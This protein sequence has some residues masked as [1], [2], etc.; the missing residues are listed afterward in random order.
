MSETTENKALMRVGTYIINRKHELFSYCD[1][2]CFKS[3][4]MRNLANYHK[5]QCYILG[6]REQIDYSK[7]QTEYIADMNKAMVL[8]NQNRLANFE[9][10]RPKRVKTA[11]DK[12]NDY[13]NNG[14]IPKS[15]SKEFKEKS[16]EDKIKF[17]QEQV[18]K[19][20]N[21]QYKAELPIGRENKLPSYDFLAF[22]FSGYLKS[23]DNP[24]KLMPAKAAQQTIR[25]LNNDWKS[26]FKSLKEY[27]KDKSKF[28][29]LP[30][31]PKYKKKDGRAKVSLSNQGGKVFYDTNELSLAN[32]KLRL[33]LG[34]FD[35][36]MKL[37]D[38][39]IIP[40]GSVYKIE[41]VWELTSQLKANESLDY[42][43]YA[44]A[45]LGLNNL[46]T[47]TNNIGVQPIIINGR[48]LK[49]INQYYNKELAKQKSMLPFRTF[50]R[51]D[52]EKGICINTKQQLSYSKAIASLTLKRNLKVDDYMHKASSIVVNHLIEN[53]IGNLIIGKNTDWK[54]SIN[55]GSVNNQNFVNIPFNKLISMITYKATQVGIKVHIVEESYTSKCSFL[56]LDE[57]PV[58]NSEDTKE[59]KFSGKRITRGLYKTGKI[60]INADVNGSFNIIRKH[61][62]TIF[63]KKNIKNL[64]FI[65]RI[66]NVKGYKQKKDKNLN[67]NKSKKK[68]A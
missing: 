5:R 27:N 37:K 44:G 40:S 36:T 42:N 46:V 33:K 7:E 26:Y 57:L 8:F 31:I 43:A 34:E 49:S 20:Q 28:K 2:M 51:Y 23:E 1:D 9:K 6:N 30:K 62:S 13:I 17:L 55:I 12:L 50:A 32:T 52:K 67:K 65:P 29:G 4:N 19:A 68:L 24:F 38:I 35:K 11:Q 53:K 64:K 45:D 54:D 25:D 21:D 10:G 61:D 66:I 3:K 60:I 15:S 22:Y 56:D 16:H 58:K 41:V 48:P 59:Y 47:I 14:I 63:N 39:R 18:N